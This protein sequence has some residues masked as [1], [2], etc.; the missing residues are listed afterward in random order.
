[1][2]GKHSN[3]YEKQG[4]AK[5]NRDEVPQPQLGETKIQLETYK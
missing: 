5:D 4:K 2:E 3:E 1:M